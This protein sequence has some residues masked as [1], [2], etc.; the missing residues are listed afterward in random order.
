MC[1]KQ[2]NQ[3]SNLVELP[4]HSLFKIHCLQVRRYH[5]IYVDE[6]DAILKTVSIS[7]KLRAI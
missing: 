6:D 4:V 1:A 3:A 7:A 5:V 2:T